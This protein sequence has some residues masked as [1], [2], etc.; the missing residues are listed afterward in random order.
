MIALGTGVKLRK[1]MD[2]RAYLAVNEV[3]SIVVLRTMSRAS[4]S[5]LVRD[6][7]FIERLD[8]LVSSNN[9]KELL[10]AIDDLPPVIPCETVEKIAGRRVDMKRVVAPMDFSTEGMSACDADAL[11]YQAFFDAGVPNEAGNRTRATN[12]V[13][14]N[15]SAVATGHGREEF[16]R[17]LEEAR[18]DA[19]RI[20]VVEPLD[21]WVFSRNLLG[22]TMRLLLALES[23]SS[24]PLDDVGMSWKQNRRLGSEV[25]MIQ[26]C[27]NPFF[28]PWKLNLS[29][30]M[31]HWDTERFHPLMSLTLGKPRVKHGILVDTMFYD[32]NGGGD[33][34]LVTDPI[35]TERYRRD[36]DSSSDIGGDERRYWLCVE[37]RGRTQVEIAHHMVTSMVN[38]VRN[39]TVDDAP[40]GWRF[41]ESS[42]FDGSAGPRFLEGSLIAQLM[43]GI[44][45][46]G[47]A[48]IRTC[49]EC[50]NAILDGNE[51]RP[52]MYCSE[53][54]RF[55]AMRRA[56]KEQSERGD[57]AR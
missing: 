25:F 2:M 40:I 56:K 16:E 49:A 12:W 7:D 46:R 33:M 51:G 55:K 29:S 44:V 10:L 21:D 42:Y 47:D 30:F 26:F 45:Y 13:L 53:S 50:G 15:R 24:S 5:N 54:C 35:A 1:D 19:S 3:G 36:F 48:Q 22:L 52:R 57:T 32:F 37:R 14:N 20:V 38:L 28:M 23:G 39:L 9:A 18:G 8:D 11:A 31:S 6:D 4:V 43:Y 27:Y 41:D 34:Y 17:D